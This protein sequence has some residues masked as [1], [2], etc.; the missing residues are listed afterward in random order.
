MSNVVQIKRTHAR[1]VVRAVFEMT[2]YYYTD[3]ITYEEGVRLSVGDLEKLF[4]IRALSD[5]GQSKLGYYFDA[6]KDVEKKVKEKGFDHVEDGFFVTVWPT[7]GE[8]F[9]R[10]L[11]LKPRA[12]QVA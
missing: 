3:V 6:L 4:K 8:L 10:D 12:A 9:V 7:G 5:W 2:I 1:L 11:F